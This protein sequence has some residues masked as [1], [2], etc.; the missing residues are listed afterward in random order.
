MRAWAAQRRLLHGQGRV[1]S[2]LVVLALVLLIVG[3]MKATSIIEG[4]LRKAAR[5]NAVAESR[6]IA[7]TGLAAA[8]SDG[9]PRRAE[10]G[11]R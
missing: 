9:H 10:L 2:A 11:V 6:L 4:G 7:N 8:M 5:Q 1:L 3:G